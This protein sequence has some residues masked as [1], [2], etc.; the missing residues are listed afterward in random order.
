[1]EDTDV[2]AIMINKFCSLITKHPAAGIWIAFGAGKNFSYIY[3]NA[4]C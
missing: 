2:V 3:I 1:M 4:I